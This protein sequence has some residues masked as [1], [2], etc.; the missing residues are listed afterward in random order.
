MDTKLTC[1][2]L[3]HFLVY[4][5]Y[6]K[7]SIFL[8]SS[9]L[10]AASITA[11]QNKEQQKPS[12][13]IKTS[14]QQEQKDEET[15][16]SKVTCKKCRNEENILVKVIN[17]IVFGVTRRVT[18]RSRSLAVLTCSNTSFVCSYLRKIKTSHYITNSFIWFKRGENK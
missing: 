1:H 6:M 18:R 3:F 15:T 2:I 16:T 12:H 10:V 4:C 11:V 8:H 17:V 9:L 13:N 5:R 14:K 7:S